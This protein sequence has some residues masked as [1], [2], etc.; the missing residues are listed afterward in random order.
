MM[1]VKV[2]NIVVGVS[3]FGMIPLNLGKSAVSRAN[4]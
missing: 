3:S 4:C 2:D 1:A